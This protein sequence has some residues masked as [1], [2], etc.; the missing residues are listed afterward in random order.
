MK[1]GKD[2]RKREREERKRAAVVAGKESE[3]RGKGER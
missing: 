1:V 2:S 3:L